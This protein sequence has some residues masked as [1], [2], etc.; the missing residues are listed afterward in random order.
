MH[1]R[2]CRIVIRRDAT[3]GRPGSIARIRRAP[4]PTGVLR[5]ADIRWKDEIDV[6][7]IS[8]SAS[9]PVP[10]RT[11]YKSA[12]ERQTL[13][14]SRA[15]R[16]RQIAFPKLGVLLHM[17]IYAESRCDLQ[18]LF[19]RRHNRCPLKRSGPRLWAS[20]PPEPV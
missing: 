18:T 8:R 4:R 19:Q 9:W 14:L 7:R 16:P 5:P 11:V 2:A 17:V 3:V 10:I 13:N 15:P 12:T 20:H 6:K 1:C